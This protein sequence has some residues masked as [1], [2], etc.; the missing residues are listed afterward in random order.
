MQAGR[1]TGGQPIWSVFKRQCCL[2]KSIS[3]SPLLSSAP[4]F[5]TLV[6]SPPLIRLLLQC[7]WFEQEREREIE[8]VEWRSVTCVHCLDA[9]ESQIMIT[10]SA[11]FWNRCGWGHRSEGGR[12]RRAAWTA[13]YCRPCPCPCPCPCSCSCPC[14]CRA[15]R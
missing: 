9:L 8:G 14:T 4:V 6:T 1:Q 10:T 12:G 11:I 5:I 2:I 13:P 15:R 3:F 7:H